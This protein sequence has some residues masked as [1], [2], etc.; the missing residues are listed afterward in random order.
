MK[1]TGTSPTDRMRNLESIVDKLQPGRL[2]PDKLKPG[3]LIDPGAVRTPSPD[4]R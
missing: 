4:K 2:V 1:L 3:E